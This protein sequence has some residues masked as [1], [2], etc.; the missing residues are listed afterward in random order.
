MARLSFWQGTSQGT[1]FRTLTQHLEAD[2]VIIGGGITGI[3]AALKLSQ[4]GKQVVVLEA[5]R[6]GQGTTG[7]STGN[8]HVIP[9]QNLYSIRDKWGKET[10]AA[11]VASRRTTLDAI[12]AVVAQYQL[13]CGFARRPHYLFAADEQQ[14]HLLS[15]E[16]DAALE[17][18]LQA[19]V[20]PDAPVGFPAGQSLR[21]EHQA[22]F[23]P[24]SY[25]RE[26]AGKIASDRCRIF[27]NSRVTDINDARMIVKTSQGTV[28][29]G[30]IIMA[31]HTPKGFNVLQ[32]ELGPYREY[33]LAARL[34]ADRYPDGIFWSMEEPSHSIRSYEIEGQKYLI[35]IGEEHKTGQQEK[36]VDYYRRVEDYLRS[37][38]NIDTIDY[39]W[40]A[41][42]YRPADDLP[43]VGKSLGSEDV[44]VATGFATNGL[45][46]GPMAAEIIADDLLGR[47][48]RW[49]KVYQAR[50]FNPAR[51]GAS[52]L[53][54]NINVAKQYIKDY[55]T[56]G[57]AENL[58]DLQQGEGKLVK[59]KGKN[60]AA[61]VDEN[62][63]F[64]AL[65]PV[66]THLGCI[67]HWNR[68]DKSWDCPCH[69]SRFQ[70]AGEVIEGPAFSPLARKAI[71]R[72]ES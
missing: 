10:T 45:L 35:V 41:Q 18:G 27:E 26:L 36:D 32:T 39:R 48:N 19:A 44:Y 57:Q 42:N 52:F 62:N 55:V 46:Y 70:P 16:R 49:A 40:S 17:A 67:V 6:V 63:Q 54:E 1:G 51:G 43:Y 7:C 15:K 2:A 64:T 9:D 53:K 21:I 72:G 20:V 66:C 59:F 31:T 50:R 38:F 61:Y 5:R 71:K 47:K 3:T 8:L 12:E 28:H 23:H 29:A 24:L 13:S 60:L 33:G 68:L 58:Q 69:G 11:V 14:A 37:R 22:Q 4:A 30:K 65:S 25:V 34:R 56:P